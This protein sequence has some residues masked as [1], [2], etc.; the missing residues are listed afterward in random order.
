MRK[1]KRER[2]QHKSILEYLQLHTDGIT[3]SEAFELFGVTRLSAIIF[4]LKKMG[5]DIES[6]RQHTINRYGNSCVYARYI[7]KETQNE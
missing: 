6:I 7:L 5:Y 1:M 3:S 4:D 2:S